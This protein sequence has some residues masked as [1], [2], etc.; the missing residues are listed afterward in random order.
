MIF[1]IA[2]KKQ[3]FPSQM[4]VGNN[5]GAR[6]ICTL[7]FSYTTR[8]YARVLSSLGVDRHTHTDTEIRV[9]AHTMSGQ[10][11]APKFEYEVG[12]DRRQISFGRLPGFLEVLLC[13]HVRYKVV[14][15]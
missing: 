15:H 8:P 1:K 5:P 10:K 2:A 6:I 7:L 4:V 12:A 13:P 3:S 14:K 11:L 9:E